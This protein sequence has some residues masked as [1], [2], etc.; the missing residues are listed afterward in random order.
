MYQAQAIHRCM[1]AGLKEVPQFTRAESL[2]VC[3]IIDEI[4][5]ALLHQVVQQ[6]VDVLLD[7]CS[8]F[9]NKSTR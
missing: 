5:L 8:L 3:E 7:H 2:R 4:N 1:A 9:L 6:A